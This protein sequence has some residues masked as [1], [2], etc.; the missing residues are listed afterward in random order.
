MIG[1][2][3]SNVAQAFQPASSR[4]P[5]AEL[6]LPVPCSRNG[7]L[8]SLPYMVCSANFGIRGQLCFISM[9][10]VDLS[11][12][13]PQSRMVLRIGPNDWPFFVRRYARRLV[14]S[15]AGICSTMSCSKSRSRRSLKIFVGMPSGEALKSR[16]RLRPRNRSRTISRVQRSPMMS[17]A[18]ATGQGE[19]LGGRAAPPADLRSNFFTPRNCH[20]N[21]L[22]STSSFTCI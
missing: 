15:W 20:K 19:R 13:N 1:L 14:P 18:C 10:R 16:K 6:R 17:S 12:A 7:R 11:H 22:Q 9:A 2:L 8:E 21:H 3:Q 4:E 5:Q